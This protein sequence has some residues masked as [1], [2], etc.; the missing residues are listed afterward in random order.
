M[1]YKIIL[2]NGEHE[3]VTHHGGFNLFTE[4]GLANNFPKFR[5]LE[6]FL[7]RQILGICIAK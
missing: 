6:K 3:M 5:T 1:G 7:N 4:E 2:E